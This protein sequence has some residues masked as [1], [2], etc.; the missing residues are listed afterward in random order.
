MATIN[1]CDKCKKIIK[2]SNNGLGIRIN[3]Y[4]GLLGKKSLLSSSYYSYDLCKKCAGSAA[5]FIKKMFPA[6]KSKK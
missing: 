3:D 1:K 6:K 5:K 4:G 2:D